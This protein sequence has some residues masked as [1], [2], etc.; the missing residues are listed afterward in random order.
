MFIFW[1][2]FDKQC[3]RGVSAPFIKQP[4][5]DTR[6]FPETRARTPPGRVAT[7]LLGPFLGADPGPWSDMFYPYQL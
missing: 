2:Y 5:W 7:R 1:F 3:L 4:I 6:H